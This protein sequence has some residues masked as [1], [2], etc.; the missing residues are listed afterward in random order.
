MQTD[1]LQTTP[2]LRLD[3]SA[4]SYYS[5]KETLSFGTGLLG[6]HWAVQGRLS[7]IGS[8][9]YLDRA[10]AKQNSYFLQATPAAYTGTRRETC[11]SMTTR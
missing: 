2:F 5:H 1:N 7:N 10:S 3:A 4:G 8:K 9:G 6:G 11:A